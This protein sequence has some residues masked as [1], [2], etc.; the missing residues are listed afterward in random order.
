MGVEAWPVAD[1]VIERFE[2]V[3]LNGRRQLVYRQRIVCEGDRGFYVCFD[4]EEWEHLSSDE[5]RQFAEREA[6]EAI[7]DAIE[8]FYGLPRQI[9]MPDPAML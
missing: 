9:P 7:A 8:K 3:G 6:H 1:G 4:L 2:R 5:D